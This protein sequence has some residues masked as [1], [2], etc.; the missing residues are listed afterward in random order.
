MRFSA[1]I[2]LGRCLLVDKFFRPI[3]CTCS[4]SLDRAARACLFGRLGPAVT[5][6]CQSTGG[7]LY[8][9]TANAV[10]DTATMKARHQICRRRQDKILQTGVR[11]LRNLFLN[12]CH[13]HFGG[14]G[15]G[16]SLWHGILLEIFFQVLIKYNGQVCYDGHMERRIT[17][18]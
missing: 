10:N 13:F 2:F 12:G 3:I 18:L 1:P 16:C 5:Q 11:C 14:D 7:I 4:H 8:E 6:W 17:L 15:G 9:V